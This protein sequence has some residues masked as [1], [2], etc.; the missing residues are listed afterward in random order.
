MNNEKK[1]LHD[2]DF[3]L[4]EIIADSTKVVDEH[5][6]LSKEEVDAIGASM[7]FEAIFGKDHVR[8]TLIIGF[9]VLTAALL[10]MGFWASTIS[11]R[12]TLVVYKQNSWIPGM[13]NAF[14]LAFIDDQEGFIPLKE[15]RVVLQ[16]DKP[17]REAILFSGNLQ[18]GQAASFVI[19]P[20]RWSAGEYNLKIQA[21]TL[22]RK[23]KTSV[24][25]NLDPHFAGSRYIESETAS[26]M[27]QSPH[28]FSFY[29]SIRNIKIELLPESYILSSSLHNLIYV[30]TTD[31]LGKPVSTRVNMKLTNGYIN[32]NIPASVKTDSAGLASFMVYPTFNILALS[33]ST[34]D[35]SGARGEWGVINLPIEPR[36]FRIRSKN[37]H[38]RAKGELSVRIYTVSKASPFFL[39]IY[40]G[41]LWSYA[42]SGYL[43]SFSTEV[44]FRAPGEGGLATVQGYGA[45]ALVGKANSSIHLWVQK[46][47]EGLRESILSV[48]TLLAAEGIE[49]VY[50]RTLRKGDFP[51]ESCNGGQLM[52]FLL[53]RLDTGFYEPT[54]YYTTRKDDEAHISCLR[55]KIKRIVVISFSCAAAIF[56]MAVV[57]AAFIALKKRPVTVEAYENEKV[58]HGAMEEIEDWKGKKV[59]VQKTPSFKELESRETLLHTGW[60]NKSGMGTRRFFIQVALLAAVMAA[61]F[62]LMASF[63]TYM[64]WTFRL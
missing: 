53:S 14:R 37:P 17:F 26:R 45:P 47:G 1:T 38:V 55:K 27:Q 31:G 57:F 5:L 33:V 49:E 2:D 29:D 51:I 25:I 10:I 12:D 4:V 18:P 61:L 22:K 52:A 30:R 8:W 64:R 46:E 28:L 59:L 20:P 50:T 56:A 7:L 6:P 44:T 11:V 15:A 48:A 42:S 40:R 41:G 16:Q 21:E 24:K 60:G 63:I 54:I 43:N 35:E 3:P 19:N 9:T 62:G 36:I 32:G 23:K 58:P 13:P 39:D 34:T